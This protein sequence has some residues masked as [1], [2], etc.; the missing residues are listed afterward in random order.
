MMPTSPQSGAPQIDW[1]VSVERYNSTQVT[2]WLTVKNLTATTL[3]YEARYA[4]LG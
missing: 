2:Y 1:D 4:V 3:S